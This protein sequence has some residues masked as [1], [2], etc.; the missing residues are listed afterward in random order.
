MFE[1]IEAICGRATAEEL[2]AM[3]AKLESLSAPASIKKKPESQK[4]SSASDQASKE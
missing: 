2:R 1:K 3:H 4:G